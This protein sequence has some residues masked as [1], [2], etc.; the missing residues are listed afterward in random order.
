MAILSLPAAPL[1]ASCRFG[2]ISNTQVFASPLSGAAQTL[3]MP[4]ARWFMRWKLPPM[5]EAEAAPWKAFLAKLRGQAGRFYGY[6]P[7]HVRQGTGGGT[8]LVNGASQTGA[9]LATDGW[10][11]SATVL[12]AGDYFAFDTPDG[13]RELKVA[14]ADVTAD[15]AGAATVTF[16][17]P[18][19]VSPADNASILLT[20]PACV[21]MLREPEI[22]WDSDEVRIYGFDFDAIEALVGT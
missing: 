1:P 22:A 9:S 7:I 14:A 6:D 8:P 2:L 20:Q 12:K 15:G 19:R 4:G 11:P 5:N 13:R 10:T 18:I 21:M 3:E 17:P 16:E